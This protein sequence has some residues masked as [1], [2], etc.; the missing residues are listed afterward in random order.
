MAMIPKHA[1]VKSLTVCSFDSNSGDGD[2]ISK[3]AIEAV[4]AFLTF[5]KDYI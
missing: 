2:K 3:V 1:T 5:K 4:E